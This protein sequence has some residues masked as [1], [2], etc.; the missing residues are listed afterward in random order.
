[1]RTFCK[2][3]LHFVFVFVPFAEGLWSVS[4]CMEI[5][6]L[7][8]YINTNT[9]YAKNNFRV[10][11]VTTGLYFIDSNYQMNVNWALFAIADYKTFE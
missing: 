3:H 8:N 7:Y 10:R 2:H 9:D 11:F 1:M 5:L 6:S 4:L